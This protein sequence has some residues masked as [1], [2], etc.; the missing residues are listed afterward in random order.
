M[1]HSELPAFRRQT[2]RSTATIRGIDGA[3]RAVIIAVFAVSA[4]AL[5]FEISLTRLFSLYFHYHFAFLAV[6]LAVLGLSLGGAARFLVGIPHSMSRLT[7]PLAALGL[8]FPL[9]AAAIAWLPDASSILP[10]AAAALVPF[11]FSGFFVSLAFARYA[12]EGGLLYAAD[13]VGAA[14]GVV[15]FVLLLNLWGAFNTLLLLGVV[16]TLLATLLALATAIER[17][18]QVA[19]LLPL[20]L[21]IIALTANLITG[22]VGYHPRQ[23]RNVPRDKTMVQ[24]L[25]DSTQDAQIIYSRWSP[26]ARVDVVETN[27]P[28]FKYIFTD[29]GAGSYMLASDGNLQESADLRSTI[30]YLPFAAASGQHTLIVGA[31]GGR[32]I[33]LALLAGAEKITAL[34]VNPAVIEATR[35][36]ANFNGAV[37]DQP[38]VSL[39]QGDAR[40]YVERHEDTYDLIYLNLV[41]TQA[42][43]AANQALVENYIFTT[44]AFR[45]Y[46]KRLA[47]GGHLAIVS[48]NALEASRAAVTALKALEETGVTPSLALDRMALWMYPSRDATRRTS[49]FLLGQEALSQDTLQRL[50]VGALSHDMQPL[51]VPRD[52]EMLFQPLR[53]GSTVNDFVEADADYDLSPT[54]DDQPF[55]FDL[56]PGL[57]PPVRLAL[58]AA[59]LIAGLL[60]LISLLALLRA[61]PGGRGR[62]LALVLY[63]CL[64]GAGFMLVEISLIQRFQLLLGY[65]VLSL[66]VVLG[67]LLLA[68]GVGSLLG[69]SWQEE[70]LARYVTLAAL[71]I[72]V[73][74]LLYRWVLPPLLAAVLPTPLS[75]RLALAAALTAVLGLPLGMPF[76]TLMRLAAPY[77]RRVAVLWGLNGAFAALGSVA[78]TVVA[79]SRGFGWAIL[80]GA[81][82]Y[83]LLSVLT[84]L[85][86]SRKWL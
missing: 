45:A 49:V 83:L 79:M 36:F 12:A 19:M 41:Y 64:I 48:H 73:V 9:S 3:R 35:A 78:A 22:I 33:I 46:L 44:E 18:L 26:F 30:D 68:G 85:M 57:P 7:L 25:N 80:G 43:E 17:R 62:W 55:F 20:S 42:A 24:V 71:W 82:L 58:L 56:D 77:G 59:A 8:S 86:P 32:D 76:P 67:T 60:L 40:T 37:L 6:S 23:L 5:I 52:F 21:T 66:L 75:L 15:A 65:P 31:G 10:R 47:P 14:A 28:Q 53:Q 72:A 11:I 1:S 29:A 13:L 81:T 54:S 2:D 70:Q 34:E 74:G 4:S 50:Q 27:D 51:F 84:T 61:G 69:Q 38:Q 16:I 63:A 39:V